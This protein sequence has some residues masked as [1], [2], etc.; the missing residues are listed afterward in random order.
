MTNY[1]LLKQFMK[2]NNLQ[3]S[4]L[5]EKFLM[6]ARKIVDFGSSEECEAPNSL[7]DIA[8]HANPLYEINFGFWYRNN[9]NQR[10][11]VDITIWQLSSGGFSAELKE[12]GLDDSGFYWSKIWP[13]G[14][15]ASGFE[16]YS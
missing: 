3:H 2:A 6:G 13:T 11:T 9:D 14:H 12:H 5:S 8:D 16:E 1:K 10:V 4:D 7:L 15:M